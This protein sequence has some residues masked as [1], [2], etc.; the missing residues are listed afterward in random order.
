VCARVCLCVSGGRYERDI[1]DMQ[2]EEASILKNGTPPP[3]VPTRPHTPVTLK[4]CTLVCDRWH[5]GLCVGPAY[6]AVPPF[7]GL[8]HSRSLARLDPHTLDCY[9][10]RLL[11]AVHVVHAVHAVLSQK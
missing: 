8:S 11:H 6:S 5:T 9:T 1:G 10:A 4:R 3:L 2:C 7:L